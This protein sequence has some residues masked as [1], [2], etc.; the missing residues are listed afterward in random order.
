M[1]CKSACICVVPGWDSCCVRIINPICNVAD[2]ACWLLKK[3]LDLILR[4]A[5]V[6]VDKSFHSLDVAKV[7]LT[8]AQGILHGAKVVLDGAIAFLVGVKITYKVGV[9]AITALVD[10]AL[11]KLINIREIYFKVALGAASRGE[12]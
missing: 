4:V 8:V 11:T 2:A 3:P 10:F 12:F 1:L 5:I 9:S 7:A 6:V